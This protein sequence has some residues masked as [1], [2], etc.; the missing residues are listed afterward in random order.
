MTTY[1]DDIVYEQR[2][3]DKL[4]GIIGRFVRDKLGIK[5]TFT[6]DQDQYADQKEATDF[7]AYIDPPIRFGVRLRTHRY[8]LDE[9]TRHDVTIRWSRPSGVRTEIDK[10][11][12]GLVDYMIYG[13]MNE[14]RSGIIAYCIYQP[15]Y[16]W[17]GSLVPYLIISNKNGDSDLGVFRRDDF[18]VLETWSLA[19]FVGYDPEGHFVHYCWCGEWGSFGVGCFLLRGKLGTWFCREHRPS[20]AFIPVCNDS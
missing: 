13:F 2:F 1:R 7:I 5:S 16:P 14:K 18:L 4:K 6:I 17:P 9:G 15:P 8:Y 11:R 12:D 3:A 10:I 19:G 20:P